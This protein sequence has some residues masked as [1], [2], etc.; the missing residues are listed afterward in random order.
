MLNKNIRPLLGK[1]V[2]TWAIQKARVVPG[3][4]RV[5]VSTDSERIAKVAR[6]AGA[7]VPFV[8]PAELATSNAGKFQVWQ[9]A[10]Q[11]CEQQD[12]VAYDL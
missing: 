7:D 1:P 3:I 12:R 6:A 11:A 10:L 8:R 2:I 5:V 4:N 9:H